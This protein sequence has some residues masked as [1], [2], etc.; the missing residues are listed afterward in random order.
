MRRSQS[1][2]G[3]ESG[4]ASDV[5]VAV[6]YVGAGIAAILVLVAA[7]SGGGEAASTA[8]ETPQDPAPLIRAE[9]EDRSAL[10]L[11]WKQTLRD[12]CENLDLQAEGLAPSCRTGAIT[13]DDRLFDEP[14]SAQLSEEGMRKVQLAMPILLETLRR[15]DDVWRN[16]ESIEL[17]GHADPRARRDPYITNLVGSHQRPLGVMIYLSS[18]WALS[19][20]D[21]EDMQRLAVISASSFSRPPK[22]CPEQN[23]SCYPFWRR[24]EVIPHM[25]GERLPDDMQHL[26]ERVDALLP[27]PDEGV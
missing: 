16:I 10:A 9:L 12:V 8:A 17:R 6:A 13:L 27:R 2:Y 14:T 4:P 21:R 19:A 5:F 3:R 24:V 26:V 11:A 1:A 23:R 7:L 15:N 25:R 18:E 20:R 22:T